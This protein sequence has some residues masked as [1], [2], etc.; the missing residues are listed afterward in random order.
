M[1]KVR[2]L[3]R[4]VNRFCIEPMH[5]IWQRYSILIQLHTLSLVIVKK[6]NI[7]HTPITKFAYPNINLN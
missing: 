7:L 2:Y 4:L 3:G 5:S 6:L 1:K